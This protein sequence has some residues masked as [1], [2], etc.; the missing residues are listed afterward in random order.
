MVGFRRIS[1]TELQGLLQQQLGKNVRAYEPLRSVQKPPLVGTIKK[2]RDIA[3]AA[4]KENKKL[5]RSN[6]IDVTI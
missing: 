4:M 5:Q 6:G 1:P 2:I 3:A